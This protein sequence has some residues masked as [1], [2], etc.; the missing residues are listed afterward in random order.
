MPPDG[1][2]AVTLS[3]GA[4]PPT[5]RAKLRTRARSIVWVC[6]SIVGPFIVTGAGVDDNGE[7]LTD[8]AAATQEK[9]KRGRSKGDK[10][11]ACRRRW[12]GIFCPEC[13]GWSEQ[14]TAAAAATSA[15]AAAATETVA[16]TAAAMTAVGST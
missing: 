7:V 15:T 11:A 16:T 6:T 13:P 4:R 9:R 1:A 10:C 12:K 14:T 3:D 8:T 2:A 5:G